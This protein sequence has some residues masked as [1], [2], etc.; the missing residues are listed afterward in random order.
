ML[1]QMCWLPVNG[2][3]SEKV[4]HLRTQ[5]HQP[6]QPYTL[7]PQ[8]AAPD[9]EIAG[10]SKGW[11]TYQKLLRAGWT[12]VATNTAMQESLPLQQFKSA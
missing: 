7:C 4:L 1:K 2:P 5:P 8:Y 10:G 6:W 12:L 11:A 3:N 9:Y